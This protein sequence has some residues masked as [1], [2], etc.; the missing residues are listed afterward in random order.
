MWASHERPTSVGVGHTSVTSP[1]AASPT[2]AVAAEA[3]PVRAG[4]GFTPSPRADHRTSG[5]RRRSGTLRAAV[6]AAR[7][8]RSAAV[9]DCRTAASARFD[10]LSGA[11]DGAA[12]TVEPRRGGGST[13]SHR[14]TSSA[15]RRCHSGTERSA[16][17]S[18]TACTM[19][20]PWRGC[21]AA[22]RTY[23]GRL[24]CYSGCR[25]CRDWGG[26]G[27]MTHAHR[28]WSFVG[29]PHS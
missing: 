15:S 8:R 20:R 9:A 18:V 14:S 23:R 25:R 16:P 22:T 24:C 6:A 12:Q 2:T 26:H 17:S 10:S 11:I 19:V 5:H 21:E 29:C 3:A 13:I 7:S 28:R 4:R 1:V 27:R